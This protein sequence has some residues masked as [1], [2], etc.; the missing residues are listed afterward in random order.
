MTIVARSGTPRE[1]LGGRDGGIFDPRA[2]MSKG[3]PTFRRMAPSHLPQTKAET[4]NDQNDPSVP[5]RTVITGGTRGIGA[6]VARKLARKGGQEVTALGRGPVNERPSWTADLGEHDGAVRFDHAEGTDPEAVEAAFARADEDGAGL[7]GLVVSAGIWM[8]TPIEGSL[9]EVSAGYREVM[10]VNVLGAVHAVA[11]F[12]GHAR[13]GG[14]SI[15]LIGST[16]GQR[17]EEGY[18]AYAAS[19]AALT[20]LAKSWCCELGPRGIRVNVV[21]PGW[22]ETDMTTDVLADPDFRTSIEAATP[23]GKVASA[24]DLAG[25]VAFLLS[26][27]AVHVTGSVI[28]VNGGSVTCSY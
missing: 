11:A 28:S 14:G 8:P 13:P 2:V 21:A 3:R 16:A 23:R 17:G 9:A 5:L 19:K 22:V 27:D 4:M 20:G 6:A 26:D 7:T 1:R 15:V 12:L 10:E 24:D 25:P 18:A